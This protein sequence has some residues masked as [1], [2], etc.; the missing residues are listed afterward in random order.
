MLFIAIT[1]GFFVENYREGLVDRE[2]E[3]EIIKSFINDLKTDIEELDV[4]IKEE[5]LEKLE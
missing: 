2:K 4:V 5:K 3:S 1:L